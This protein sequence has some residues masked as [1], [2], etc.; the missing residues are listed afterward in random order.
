P[1]HGVVLRDLESAEPEPSLLIERLSEEHANVRATD[2]A[3]DLPTG[4]LVRVIP[5]H[6][7]VVSNLVDAVW[8]VDGLHVLSRLPVAARGR[9]T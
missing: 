2:G 3:S 6:S 4:A 7:C 8:L 1:G 5:N 9:I